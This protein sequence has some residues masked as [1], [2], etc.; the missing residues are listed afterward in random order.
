MLNQELGDGPRV[1]GQQL[2]I[3]SSLHAVV[4]RLDRLFRRQLPLLGGRLA[5]D[6]DQAPDLSDL[7]Q[8]TVKQKVAQ[9]PQ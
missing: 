4:G 6:A 2:T 8:T 1:A 9:Q 5:A 7:E 3:G